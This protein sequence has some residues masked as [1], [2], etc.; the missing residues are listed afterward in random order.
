MISVFS[1]N[2]WICF[3]RIGR[4]FDWYNNKKKLR[5]KNN[6]KNKFS[7][8]I[9]VLRE[10]FHKIVQEERDLRKKLET[11]NKKCT[12]FEKRYKYVKKQLLLANADL[13]RYKEKEEQSSD[14]NSV[15]LWSFFFEINSIFFR[16]TN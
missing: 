4:I 16:I 2:K 9:Q 6:S 8:E 14:G 13:R 1:Y 15:E 5:S 3:E 7:G 12:A 11:Q 10:S